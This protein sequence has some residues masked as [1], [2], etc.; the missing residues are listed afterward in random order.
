[1]HAAHACLA[2]GDKGHK[3]SDCPLASGLVDSG[4]AVAEVQ[5]APSAALAA[6]ASAPPRD[7]GVARSGLDRLLRGA[8]RHST[9]RRWSGPDRLPRLRHYADHL[10]FCPHGEYTSNSKLFQFHFNY[11]ESRFNCNGE[12]MTQ[13]WDDSTARF[14]ACRHRAEEGEQR[15]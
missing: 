1:M 9:P 10:I 11:G 8:R 2:C 14:H 5:A 4:A 12:Q 15:H 6:P 3:L 7:E 13:L